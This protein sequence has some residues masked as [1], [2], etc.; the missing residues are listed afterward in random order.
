MITELKELLDEVAA[1]PD[2]QIEEPS[3]KIA[4]EHFVVGRIDDLKLRRIFT[5]Y[6]RR[7]REL[8]QLHQAV[9]GPMLVARNIPTTI[10]TKMIELQDELDLL[11]QIFFYALSKR[12]GLFGRP[13]IH[14]HVGWLVSWSNRSTSTPACSGSETTFDNDNNDQNT[15]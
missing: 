12:F 11:R 3:L 1:I 6:T 7:V 4:P 13:F 10:Q 15:N 9:R 5:A 8:S 14:V 2:D